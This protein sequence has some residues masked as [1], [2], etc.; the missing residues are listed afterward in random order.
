MLLL[1]SLL[2]AMICSLSSVLALTGRNYQV[3][4]SSSSSYLSLLVSIPVEA[5]LSIIGIIACV[6]ILAIR[7]HQMAFLAGSIVATC[8][9]WNLPSFFQANPYRSDSIMMI[10]AM[11]QVVSSGTTLSI[12]ASEFGYVQWPGF[13]L[14]GSMVSESS[15]IELETLG[16]LF[17]IAAT[18]LSTL[19]IYIVSCRILSDPTKARISTFQV[20]FGVVYFQFHFAPQ[21][22]GSTLLLLSIYFTWL[23]LRVSR[24]ALLITATALVTTHPTSAFLLC[25]FLVALAIGV[26][27]TRGSDVASAG[28]FLQGVR[29]LFGFAARGL[30]PLAIVLIFVIWSIGFVSQS[31]SSSLLSSI[32]DS[33]FGSRAFS[34]VTLSPQSGFSPMSGLIR[35]L[36][37]F[38]LAGMVLYSLA[39]YR[40]AVL[41][42]RR[43]KIFLSIWLVACTLDWLVSGIG[44]RALGVADRALLYLFLGLFLVLLSKVPWSVSMGR[45]VIG[46]DRVLVAVA[47]ALALVNFSTVYSDFNFY[48]QPDSRLVMDE[49][50]ATNGDKSQT[51]LIVVVCHPYVDDYATLP[52]FVP[53]DAGDMADLSNI[54]DSGDL[55]VL[56]SE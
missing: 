39:T 16:I 54:Y 33:V 5:Q 13:I 11:K 34:D 30:I 25:L 1:S 56:V 31:T 15:D 17:P 26:H 53:I 21:S 45:S 50:L 41:M 27:A 20:S 12:D 46:R 19:T 28:E 10:D 24:F 9:L 7:G 8:V 14:F 36:S 6:V 49:F 3:E 23:D 32:L 40:N 35:R 42:T 51:D 43:V 4:W 37:A 44:T 38:I 22:I 2:T 47:V 48:S 29:S 55:W 18:I 52:R